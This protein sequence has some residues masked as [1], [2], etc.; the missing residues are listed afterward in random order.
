MKRTYRVIALLLVILML[1]PMAVS[2]KKDD[3]DTPDKTT[4]TTTSPDPYATKLPEK[5]W[6]GKEL[7]VLG[8]TNPDR[9]YSRMDNFEISR[10]ELPDDVVGKAVWERNNALKAK[11]NF[12][13]KHEKSVDMPN[14]AVLDTYNKG[15]D[16]YDVAF[17]TIAAGFSYAQRGMY[18]DLRETEYIDF[19]HPSWDAYATEQMTISGRT[20]F[21]VGDLNLQTLNT[22]HVIWYNREMARQNNLGMLEDLVY[23]NTW[24]LDKYYDILKSFAFDKDGNGSKGDEFDS[25]GL[26]IASQESTAIFVVGGGFRLTTNENGTIKFVEADNKTKSI[27]DKVVKF[28]CDKDI[29]MKPERFGSTDAIWPKPLITFGDERALMLQ[30]SLYLM[31]QNFL[32][33]V[34]FEFG[35]L[36]FPKHDAEQKN[37]YTTINVWESTLIGIPATVSE[38]R[39]DFVSFA[40]QALT[41]ASTKTTYHA[42]YETKCKHQDAYDEKC[43]QILDLIFSNVVYDIGMMYDLGESSFDKRDGLYSAISY[44]L[45]KLGKN[46]YMNVYNR[47]ADN[48]KGQLE[49]ILADFAL[50]E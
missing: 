2:C 33:Y 44:T 5:D 12:V 17:A 45:P 21:G 41:E 9:D 23:N 24:T 1:I 39:L 50:V 37:Y 25:F 18:K 22:A 40:L 29:T 47:K 6:E 48:A 3:V 49:E 14:S 42:Y 35:Y 30:S 28:A 32:D 10:D 27:I 16:L 43:A 34:E 7:I 46:T 4:A 38:S 36:P 20:F 13:V 19:T 11:Y 8:I 15:E 26:A 31:D